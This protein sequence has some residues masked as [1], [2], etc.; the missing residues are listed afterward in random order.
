MKTSSVSIDFC[1]KL[2]KKTSLNSDLAKKYG[3]ERIHIVQK[4]RQNVYTYRNIDIVN[5][6]L[7]PN[8][9]FSYCKPLLV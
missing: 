8:H 1:I 2:V 4:L 7:L 3:I 6:V 9:G 5:Y